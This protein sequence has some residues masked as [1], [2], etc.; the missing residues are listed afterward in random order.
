MCHRVGSFANETD[1]ALDDWLVLQDTGKNFNKIIMFSRVRQSRAF[2]ARSRTIHHTASD[3]P[4][5]LAD[6]ATLAMYYRFADHSRQGHLVQWGLGYCRSCEAA[7]NDDCTGRRHRSV[8]QQHNPARNQPRTTE[9]AQIPNV[10]SRD[11]ANGPNHE[12][13]RRRRP[14]EG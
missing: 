7:K 3:R 2:L 11:D 9:R 1:A 14:H 8:F 13:H 12:R 10:V 5:L 4:P 6:A